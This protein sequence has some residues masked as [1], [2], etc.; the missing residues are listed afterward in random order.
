[1]GK[2]YF[3]EYCEKS[4][5]DNYESRKKHLNSVNHKLLVKLHYNQYRDFKT[6]V[7]EESMKNFCMRSLKG[8][9]PFGEKCYN[10][11]FTQDQ[12]KQIEFQGYQLEQESLE[13]RRQKILNADLSN[14]YKSIGAV[15]KCFQNP[16]AQVF[17][18]SEQ[19]NLPPS[20]RET[21][22]Q[23]VENMEFTEWG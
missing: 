13:K 5:A 18:N 6:L 1:M 20:L 19:T 2:K 16:L 4:M 22:L 11:H 7:Q 9:C 23:D 21:T 3:C 12:L 10:T 17:M 15:P 8:Q 14:W